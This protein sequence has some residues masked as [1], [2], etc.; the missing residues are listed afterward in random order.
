[1]TR[2]KREKNYWNYRDETNEAE[3]KRGVRPLIYLPAKRNLKHLPPDYAKHP[4]EE[5]KPEVANS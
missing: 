1:M 4:A 3:R 5:I 2:G